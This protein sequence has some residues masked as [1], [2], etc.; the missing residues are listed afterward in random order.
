MY[1]IAG[2][3]G[4]TAC[5]VGSVP[6]AAVSSIAIAGAGGVV[7][8]SRRAGVGSGCAG[9]GGAGGGSPPAGASSGGARA[10]SADA[11]QVQQLPLHLQLSHSML[12]LLQSQPEVPQSISDGILEVVVVYGAVHLGQLQVRRFSSPCPM[13]FYLFMSTCGKST[14]YYGRT[15]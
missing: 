12:Q 1:G 7:T 13:A 5:T 15:N 14:H 9:G 10:A 3:C 2:G 8:A 4:G 11:P 6:G